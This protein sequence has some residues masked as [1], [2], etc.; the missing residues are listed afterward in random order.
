MDIKITL[1]DSEVTQVVA[2]I[3]GQL[4]IIETAKADDELIRLFFERQLKN[5]VATFE[6]DKAMALAGKQA[7][8]RVEME[9]LPGKG[10]IIPGKIR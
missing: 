5:V 6:R 1:T 2:A 4:R 8:E 3:K 10:E 7:Q 9:F